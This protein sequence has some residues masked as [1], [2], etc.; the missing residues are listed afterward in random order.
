MC[1]SIRKTDGC[2]YSLFWFR[3][4]YIFLVAE[5]MINA[6]IHIGLD[7]KISRELVVN[8]IKGSIAMLDEQDIHLGI[9]RD[10]VSSPLEQ[11]L[12]ILIRQMEEDG[13]RKLSLME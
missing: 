4:A 8:T 1:R 2:C 10:Q 6:G 11:L 7:S 13:I 9:L 3:P 12:R 5:A